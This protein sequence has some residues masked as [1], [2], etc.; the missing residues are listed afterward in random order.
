M[1]LLRNQSVPLLS[2][3]L[4][5]SVG[6]T[7]VSIGPPARIIELRH[8][9]IAVGLH[10]RDRRQHRHRRL[11]DREDVHVALEVAEDV[12]HVVDVVVE[13]EAPAASGTSRASGQ[14]VM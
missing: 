12:A 8:V 6:L 7:R 4:L 2:A 3:S 14:S 11:A 13:V 9:R 10:Q 1:T 5:T